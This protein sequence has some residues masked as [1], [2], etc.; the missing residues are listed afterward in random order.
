MPGRYVHGGRDA[1]VLALDGAGLGSWDIG[2]RLGITQ[3]R[4]QQLL[5]E[6]HG[7]AFPDRLPK[8]P[9]EELF[10]LVQKEIDRHGDHWGRSMLEGALVDQNPQ[11]SFSRREL[12]RAMS[13]LRPEAFDARRDWCISRLA[14]GHYHAPHFGYS[15]HMDLDCK[16]EEY[17]IYVGA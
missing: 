10:T 16:L 15:W 14:R 1:E 7:P 9:R 11:W 5:V 3:R 17:G 4:V 6:L 2:L 12:T 13:E 8:P